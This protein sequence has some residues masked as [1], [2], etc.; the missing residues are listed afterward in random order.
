MVIVILLVAAASIWLLWEWRSG[1]LAPGGHL[2]D[3]RLA[4]A[5]AGRRRTL[6]TSA[7]LNVDAAVSAR[8]VPR[9]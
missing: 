2:V 9:H 4:P 8:A 1:A 3:R 7:A 5:S 6:P